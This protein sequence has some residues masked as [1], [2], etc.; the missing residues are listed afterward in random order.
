MALPCTDDKENR[1]DMRQVSLVTGLSIAV[2]MATARAEAAPSNG[3]LTIQV[4][5]DYFTPDNRDR[6]YSNGIRLDWLPA[7]STTGHPGLIERLARSLP[8]IGTMGS[9]ER[10]GWSL[11]QSLFTPQNTQ[12]SAPIPND[13]PYAGWLY[14]GLTLLKSSAS[15]RSVKASVNQLDTLEFDLGVVGRAAMGQLVQ[16]G[17][18]D[19]AF[20]NENPKGWHNQLKSEPGLLISYDH[21]WRALWQTG[22]GSFGADLTPNVG[23]ELGNVQIDASA[24]ATL[25][26]GRNLPN[27]F[28]PPRIRPGLSGSNFFLSGPDSAS[29]FGY[30]FFVGAEGR[31]VARNIFLDG[32]SFATS[33]SVPKKTFVADLQAGVA[34]MLYGVRIT[35][36]EVLRTKEF[37]GQHNNDS[38]GALSMS[39]NF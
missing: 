13:R 16:R 31:A 12:L 25:R 24:G 8:F 27:D 19:W 5:N 35:A 6:H 7:P 4:E 14:G 28:G 15:D 2:L 17:F 22:S 18:H 34:V 29:K 26:F 33:Q 21:K 32:N 11:G 36:T 3:T 39:F 23:A 9:A 38:F 10:V 30:Y 1:I 37:K 20:A